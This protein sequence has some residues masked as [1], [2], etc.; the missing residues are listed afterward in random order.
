MAQHRAAAIAIWGFGLSVLLWGPS[1]A[2]AHCACE[3]IVGRLHCEVE[4]FGKC[5]GDEEKGSPRDELDEPEPRVIAVRILGPD[6]QRVD[7]LGVGEKFRVRVEFDREPE[8]SRLTVTVK[9]FT[10]E[11]ATRHEASVTTI[12]TARTVF[13]SSLL[14]VTEPKE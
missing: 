14:R 2:Q 9:T 5:A 3:G 12:K 13:L 1:I 7:T 8:T 10:P 11:G 4:H 6:G